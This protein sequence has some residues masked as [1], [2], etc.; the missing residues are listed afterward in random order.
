MKCFKMILPTFMLL[1]LFFC[2]QKSKAQD[3][4]K[5]RKFYL[6]QDGSNYFKLTGLAQIWARELDY[7]PGSII[8]GNPK[9]SGADIGIRRIRVQLYGQL[10]DRVFFYTQ[11]GQNNMNSISDRKVGFFVHDVLGEYVID[12]TKMSIGAGLSAWSGLSRFSASSVGSI[13]G[14]DLP[15]FMEATNDVTDQFGRKYSVYVKGKLGKLDYRIAFAQ[16]MAIQKSDGYSAVTAIGANSSFSSES[17]NFQYDSY[18]QYQ[19]K[20]QESNGMPYATGTYLGKKTVFNIGVGCIYQKDAMWHLDAD[21]NT[22]HSNMAHFAADVFYDAPIGK[23]GAAVSFYGNVTH[24]DFGNDYIRNAGPINPAN[25]SNDLTV[26]N[27]GGNKFPAYGTGTILYAQLG[28]KLKD[29]L[30]GKTEL[31]PYASVQHANYN[32]LNQSMNYYDVGV[33]WILAG[34]TSKFTLSYQNRPVYNIAGDLMDRKAAILVQYQV[35]LN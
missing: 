30:I 32:R 1:V 12:K 6:N 13:M 15:L 28:Y 19:F 5:D 23:K 35:F 25:G 33:N 11:I 29:D 2:S 17:P 4:M 27:G 3:F 8:F 31:M 24:Y 34:Q 22:I 16:P 21:K 7:N 18:F 14:I 9:S 20:E 10:T 26:L